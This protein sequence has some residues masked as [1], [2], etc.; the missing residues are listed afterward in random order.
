MLKATGIVSRVDELGRIVIPVELRKVMDIGEK[1]PLEIYT[2]AEKIIL[3]KY[4]PACLF[5]GDAEGLTVHR[6]KNIC[7]ACLTELTK[8]TV[9]YLPKVV[10][11]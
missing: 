5:C 1:D 7:L 3:K 10:S 4:Q 11:L 6:G 8:E 2:D 9:F